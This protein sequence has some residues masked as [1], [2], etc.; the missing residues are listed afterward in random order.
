MLAKEDIDLYVVL[1]AKLINRAKRVAEVM[2]VIDSEKY[3]PF[4]HILD[5]NIS[6]QGFVNLFVCGDDDLF[7]ADNGIVYSFPADLLSF[8]DE[9]IFDYC[10]SLNLA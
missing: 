10:Q 3:L 2:Q 1:R 4:N 8:P 7:V 5:V 9:K 6:D